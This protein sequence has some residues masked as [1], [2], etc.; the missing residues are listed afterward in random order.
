MRALVTTTVRELRAGA[1]ILWAALATA[2][3]P[4]L[5]PLLP[6][7]AHG[8]ARDLR[9][10]TALVLAGL[11]GVALALFT[12]AAL[13]AGDVADGSIGFFLALP[14]SAATI[15]AARVLATLLLVY[16]SIAIVLLPV[17]LDGRMLPASD[18][19]PFVAALLVAP[20]GITLVAHHL[21]VAIRSRSPWLL[22]DLV[23]L[24]LAA[25]VT[26]QALV[27]LYTSAAFTEL[28]IGA[29]IA[30][31]VVA[32]ALLASGGI[33]LAR[34]GGLLR[35][36]HRAQMTSVLL[37]LALASGAVAAY[38]AWVLH[39]GAADVWSIDAV[40][41][42]PAGS[43]VATAVNVRHRP[44]YEPW[45]LFDTASGRA[46]TLGAELARGE[47][48]VEP[49]FAPDGQSVVWL[50][51]GARAIGGQGE[52]EWTDLRGAR[53]RTLDT[54][55]AVDDAWQATLLP[56]GD[57]LA[58]AQR[59]RLAAWDER[60][61]R[62]LAAMALPRED[63][64]WSVIR[65]AGDRLRLARFFW[66][67][68]ELVLER[69][70]LALGDRRAMRI[71]D[72]LLGDVAPGALAFSADGERLLVTHGLQGRGGVE[73]LPFAGSA[74]RTLVARPDGSEPWVEPML[75]DAILLPDGRI[76]AAVV[77]DHRAVLHLYDR[78]GNEERDLPLG[79]ARFLWL[80]APWRDGVLPYTA[81]VPAPAG[82]GR[83]FVGELREI[84][85]A[86]G[87]VRV[88]A[89][90]VIPL[91]LF[92]WRGGGDQVAPGAP[93]TQLFRDH[94]GFLVRVTPTG[95]RQQL[96]PLPAERDRNPS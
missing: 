96:L 9:V 81:S 72:L 7:V 63:T 19:A 3:L 91:S 93:A 38:A 55:V 69:F 88:V 12:G 94:D 89:A 61:R 1:P 6:G 71:P 95:A 11:L 37:G 46:M 83:K 75:A 68:E 15:W 73:T 36:I 70:E 85:L 33:A 49:A 76:A 39:P 78:D 20:L 50:R 80:G 40:V 42:A 56:D 79:E 48:F 34:G 23:G 4:W 77:R 24:A 45:M 84:D 17:L 14:L 2:A 13:L 30:G 28:A 44:S 82:V 64:R 41:A 65:F 60:G 92:S 66:R 8:D 31:A 10:T 22:V 29:S 26:D 25:I 21:A 32:A 47:S 53:P 5:T 90:R 52:V 74:P 16:G 62:L 43:W 51:P 67:Q 86:S 58:V 54:G 27:R 18:R 57:R 59:D 87:R 35:R